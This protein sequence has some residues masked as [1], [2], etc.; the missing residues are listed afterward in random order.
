[1]TKRESSSTDVLATLPFAIDCDR[2]Y[3]SV[4]D[5]YQTAEYVY[6][7]KENL[8]GYYKIGVTSNPARRMEQFGVK[9]PFRTFIVAILECRDAYKTERAL[10]NAYR[11]KRVHGEWF[12]LSG[13]D[14][15]QIK[16]LDMYL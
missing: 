11:H 1:M 14:I 7:I 13:W 12:N 2:Y 3:R 4:I 6:L 15:G 5:E 10:H 9:L 8:M 16:M